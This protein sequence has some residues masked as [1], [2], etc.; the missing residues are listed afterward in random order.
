MY[1]NQRTCTRQFRI[2][3]VHLTRI[4]YK[5]LG[6]LQRCINDHCIILFY[7]IIYYNIRLRGATHG[8]KIQI[9]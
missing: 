7:H 3:I 5:R 2:I 9:Q 4:T 1:Q 6:T 8:M